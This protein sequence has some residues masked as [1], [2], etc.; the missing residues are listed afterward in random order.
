MKTVLS[1]F[2]DTRTS[3]SGRSR[4]YLEFLFLF[5]GLVAIDYYIWVNARATVS[6]AYD[7]WSFTEQLQGR[8][9]TLVDFFK[10]EIDGLLGRGQRPPEAAPSRVVESRPL[11][12][13]P[14]VAPKP[15][16]VL[17]R[18]EI[19]RLHMDL[20]VREGVT[21]QALRNAVGHVPSTAL[22]GQIGNVALAAHRDTFFRPLRNIRKGD[23]ITV[24]TLHGRYR[25]AVKSIQIVWPSDTQVL[26]ASNQ[27]ELTLITCYPFYYVGSAPR[28]FIV[29][30]MQLGPALNDQSSVRAD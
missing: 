20:M 2:G 10:Q 15:L 1:E 26:N 12:P 14:P 8:S 7:H 11:Q 5:L 23:V 6:Q 4:K 13:P 9:A 24:D 21:D 18:L 27:P 17:G 28:R 25:Y 30:A 29:Q 22:P 16:A 19:P 3:R